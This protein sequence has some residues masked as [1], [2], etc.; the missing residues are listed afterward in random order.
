MTRSTR[1]TPEELA[2]FK[3]ANNAA[4]DA[5]RKT[6]IIEPR[7]ADRR[8]TITWMT[9]GGKFGWM[10]TRADSLEE[11]AEAFFAARGTG[12][13]RNRI[14]AD[15]EAELIKRGGQDI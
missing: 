10:T 12:R 5:S 8:F 15:A 11:A 6:I 13:G 3:A 2:A 1:R 4:A 14:P 7:K 9:P